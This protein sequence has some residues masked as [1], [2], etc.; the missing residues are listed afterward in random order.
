MP[1]RNENNDIYSDIF[2]Q[3]LNENEEKMIDEAASKLEKHNPVLYPKDVSV[4]ISKSIYSD[5]KKYLYEHGYTFKK[6]YLEEYFKNLSEEILKSTWQDE[7]YMLYLRCGW[8]IN[9]PCRSGLM[10]RITA[11]E[12][13][14][15]G[16]IPVFCSIP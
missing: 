11:S 2:F 4:E 7:K 14:G 16:S 9:Q 3:Y 1:I 13:V 15:A 6:E 12:V 5:Y 10:V 8:E